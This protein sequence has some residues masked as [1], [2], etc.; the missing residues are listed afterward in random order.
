M[1]AILYLYLPCVNV[2]PLFFIED[3][4]EKGLFSEDNQAFHVLLYRDLPCERL[5]DNE[6]MFNILG[7]YIEMANF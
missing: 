5:R 2:L 1:T 7:S 3:L 6:R 4:K